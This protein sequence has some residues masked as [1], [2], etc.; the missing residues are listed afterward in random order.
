MRGIRSAKNRANRVG[1]H[2]H[3]NRGG[4][5][6]KCLHHPDGVPSAIEREPTFRLNRPSTRPVSPH[7][8]AAI[9]PE[10]YCSL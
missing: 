1:S 6:H 2:L 5:G 4:T 7:D 3:R 10:G 9:E 8:A